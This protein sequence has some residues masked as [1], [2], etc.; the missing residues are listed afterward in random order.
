MSDSETAVANQWNPSFPSLCG[1]SLFVRSEFFM[2]MKI[3]FM[4]GLLGYD[5]M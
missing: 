3:Q 1:K 2:A 5:T 4:H